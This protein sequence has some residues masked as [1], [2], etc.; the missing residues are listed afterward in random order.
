MCRGVDESLVEGLVTLT[1]TV[2]WHVGAFT[3]A[4][5]VV[6]VWLALLPQAASTKSR[7]RRNGESL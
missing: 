6:I 5:E 3:I 2:D 1:E 4:W 7:M